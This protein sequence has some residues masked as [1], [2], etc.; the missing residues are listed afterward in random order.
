MLK[1][2]LNQEKIFMIK[3]FFIFSTTGDKRI[4]TIIIK[5]SNSDF[6]QYTIDEINKLNKIFFFK[7]KYYQRKINEVPFCKEFI[8]TLI[9]SKIII[10]ND[11]CITK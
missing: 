11:Q 1:F 6:R 10:N 9:H 8:H 7:P 3:N 4:V 2:I 5:R